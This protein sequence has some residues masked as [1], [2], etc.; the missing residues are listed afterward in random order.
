ML[1]NEKGPRTGGPSDIDKEIL[2]S[3]VQ[4]HAPPHEHG[5]APSETAALMFRLS[6]ASNGRDSL[7]SRGRALRQVTGCLRK[8]SNRRRRRPTV[9]TTARDALRSIT[10]ETSRPIKVSCIGEQSR[11]TQELRYRTLARPA[12]SWRHVFHDSNMFL[13]NV[14]MRTQKV[15]KDAYPRRASSSSSA[16]KRR[17]SSFA[18]SAPV[19][20]E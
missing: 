4:S 1:L 20:S 15:R 19:A 3:G 13:D 6:D 11:S 8:R 12:T 5:Q 18:S 9:V 2:G 10:V 14:Y 7:K 16:M 17:A